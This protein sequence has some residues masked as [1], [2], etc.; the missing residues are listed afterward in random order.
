[1]EK[2]V[3]AI[4][5]A[6]NLINKEYNYSGVTNDF[7]FQGYK[8][9]YLLTNENIKGLLELENISDYHNALVVCSSGDQVFSLINKGILDIETFDINLMAEYI[10]LGLKKAMI[11][12]Y[13]YQDFLANL[14]VL[15]NKNISLEELTSILSSLLPY[16]DEKYR[17]FWQSIIDYN[18]N[19][20]KSIENKKNLIL[21]FCRVNDLMLQRYSKRIPFL[22]NE[23]EYNKLKNNLQKANIN[24]KE[25]NAVSLPRTYKKSS[26]IIMLSNVL[27]YFDAYWGSYWCYSKLKEY[28]QSLMKIIS[29]DGL[30]FLH[31]I[32]GSS[33]DTLYL[34][35]RS[36]NLL[37]S[38]L[39]DEDIR[40]ISFPDDKFTIIDKVILKRVK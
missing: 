27:D 40:D 28:E 38:E 31:Y 2:V 37:F 13:S 23:E 8:K 35:F 22:E 26:D 34:P 11:M 24:F 29:P 14:K 17:I 25:A 33:Y 1:M 30:I 15:L 6:K 5:E 21:L 36:T 12:K 20:Q 7:S 39:Y 10:A 4:K 19:L 3:E 9:S 16:M 32:F 18:Y